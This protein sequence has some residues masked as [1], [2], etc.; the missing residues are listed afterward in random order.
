VSL[1]FL[2]NAEGVKQVHAIRPAYI[3]LAGLGAG[4]L[5]LVVVAI[6]IICSYPLNRENKQGI[7]AGGGYDGGGGGYTGVIDHG[8]NGG[9]VRYDAF[10]EGPEQHEMT[11]KHHDVDEHEYHGGEGYEYP[12]QQPQQQ[13]QDY[14]NENEMNDK[15]LTQSNYDSEQAPTVDDNPYFNNAD[16]QASAAF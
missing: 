4:N 5:L 14:Y 1:L 8:D 10:N 2:S 7:S 6:V 16:M 9:G 3:V 12:E 11:T 13:Q 15:R